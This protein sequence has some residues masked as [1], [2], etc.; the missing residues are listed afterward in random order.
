METNSSQKHLAK[1]LNKLSTDKRV[2][3]QPTVEIIS[4]DTIATGIHQGNHESVRASAGFNAYYV[5]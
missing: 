5:S 2:W 3:T 1:G 4:N